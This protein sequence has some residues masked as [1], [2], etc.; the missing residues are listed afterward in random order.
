MTTTVGEHSRAS[1]YG[2]HR[3]HTVVD[4]FG[5]WLGERKVR[6]SVRF[7][8]A[9]FADLGCGYQATLARS[10][11]H[12][13]ESALLV[14]VALAPD[15]KRH[16][17]VQAI[18]GSLLDVLPAVGDSSWTSSCVSPYWSTSGSLRRS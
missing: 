4:R 12:V 14:D 2:Q 7:A 11:L 8:G 13:A 6:R 9:R 18:E 1:A 17:K 5:V 10:V 16:P 3:S 15:L